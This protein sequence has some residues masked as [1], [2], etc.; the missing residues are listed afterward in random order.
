M[1]VDH[2]KSN[3]VIEIGL[4]LELTLL[5]CHGMRLLSLAYFSDTV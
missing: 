4:G 1:L 2:E 3:H 5:R